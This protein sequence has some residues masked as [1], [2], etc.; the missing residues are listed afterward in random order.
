MRLVQSALIAVAAVAVLS[1]CKKAGTVEATGVY[2]TRSTCP[3]VGIPA[4]TAAELVGTHH[5]PDIRVL[6]AGRVVTPSIPVESGGLEVE[7]A[8][9]NSSLHHSSR[10][11]TE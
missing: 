5:Q 11:H 3:Q 7:T 1:G 8:F 2:V 6:P 10:F 9:A 4:I